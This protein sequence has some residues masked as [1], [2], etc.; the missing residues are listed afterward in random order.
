MAPPEIPTFPLGHHLKDNNLGPGRV[1]ASKIIAHHHD[2][3]GL[4]RMQ[5]SDRSHPLQVSNTACASAGEG[6]GFE[7]GKALSR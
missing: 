5:R 3:K 6:T 7:G 1:I 2:G 4:V